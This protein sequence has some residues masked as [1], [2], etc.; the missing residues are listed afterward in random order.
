LSDPDDEICSGATLNVLQASL[1]WWYSQTYT[2]IASTFVVQ[3]DEAGSAIGWSLVAAATPFN[4]TSALLAPSCTQAAT[5]LTPVQDVCAKTPPPVAAATTVLTQ[6][7]YETVTATTGS[8]DVPD[9]AITPPPALIAI[10]QNGGK[11]SAGTPFVFFSAY[12]II[13]KSAVTG[14]GAGQAVA[15]VTATATYAMPSPFSFEYD[16]A[17]VNGQLLVNANVTG[18]VNPAFLGI[19]NVTGAAAGSWVAEPTAV[20]VVSRIFAVS[21]ASLATPTPTLPSGFSRY[22]SDGQQTTVPPATSMDWSS[23]ASLQLP[24]IAHSADITATTE[25]TAPAHSSNTP[26]SPVNTG[27]PT[28]ALEVLTQALATYSQ[29]PPTNALEVLQQAQSAYWTRTSAKAANNNPINANNSATGNPSRFTLPVTTTVAGVASPNI[30]STSST[31]TS[32]RAGTGH[33]TSSSHLSSVIMVMLGMLPVV[34]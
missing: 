6:T 29:P 7:A 28:N 12:E 3:N 16:G 1:D 23:A 5:E 14:D 2:Y 11:F 10:P 9:F 21:Q 30:P 25:S 31:S 8:G 17:D 19:V 4:V 20:V 18:D 32:V 15:C 22:T 26:T 27:T 13:T 34:F 24:S 33:K